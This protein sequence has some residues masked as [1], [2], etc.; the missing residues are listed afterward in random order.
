MNSIVKG[1]SEKG[2]DVW[3]LTNQEA[4]WPEDRK[5]IVFEGFR[6][7]PQGIDVKV[8]TLIEKHGF[9]AIIWSTGL[10][11]FFFRNKIDVLK[12]PVIAVVTSPRYSF[13]ELLSLDKDLIIN[14]EFIKHF[15]LGPFI[16]KKRIKAFLS[17]PNLKAI[18][19]ECEET[20]GRY[21]SDGFNRDKTFV[22]PPPI[23]EDFLKLLTEVKAEENNYKKDYFKILYF[24]PPINL[25]GIDTLIHAVKIGRN[26]IENIRLDILSRIEYEGL[27]RYERKMYGLIRRKG[28]DSNVNVISGM[29]APRE[30]IKHLLSSDLVCLPFKCVVSDAPIAV[31]ETIATGIPLITT[32]VAGVSEFA[33][34]GRCYVIPPRDSKSLAEA[35]MKVISDRNRI[36]QNETIM[37]YILNSHNLENFG[38]SFDMILREVI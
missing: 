17:I 36:I 3:I 30:I 34:I 7:F 33:K 1:L 25:R 14:R 4:K 21:I 6:S 19:F 16:S 22:I 11:D 35:I 2:H 15:F 13:R 31:L 5:I 12:I 9:D 26:K 18:V 32:E 28:L 20:L 8:G 37:L 24:G 29:L 23:P 27:L 10:T 38:L